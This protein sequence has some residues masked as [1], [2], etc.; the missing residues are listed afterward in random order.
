MEYHQHWYLVQA[1]HRRLEATS[2]SPG[3]EKLSTRVVLL[4]LEK[5]N[6]EKE[7]DILENDPNVLLMPQY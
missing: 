3:C 7:N 1:L 2:P 5:G 4:P 6:R